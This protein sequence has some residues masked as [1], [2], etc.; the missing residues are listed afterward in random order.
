MK[1][2][3]EKLTSYNIFNYLLP[4]ALFIVFAEKISSY[5]LSNSDPIITGFTAYFVG[6]VISRM[7]SLFVEPALRKIKFLRFKEYGDFVSASQKDSKLEVLSEQ[8]NTYR[9]LISMIICVGLL[10]F[11]ELASQR[12]EFLND[13][14]IWII[15]T[16]L[17]V[18][19]LFSYKKQTKYIFDRVDRILKERPQ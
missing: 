13:W 3:L 4:G 18:L 11:Y 16:L 5:Q 15:I 6:M 10:K 8:N 19:F 17:F 1:D 9:S 14:S 12:I 7:G 2:I